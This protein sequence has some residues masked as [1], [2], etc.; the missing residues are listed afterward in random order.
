M[1]RSIDYLIDL[2]ASG[3]SIERFLKNRGYTKQGIVEIKKGKDNALVNGKWV[4]M[5]YILSEGDCLTINIYEDGESLKI[6]PVNLPFKVV[7]EDEDII[8]VDK[9]ANMPIHPSMNNY[10][11]TLGNALAYYYKSKGEKLIFRCI[12]RLDRDT[13]GLTIIAKHYL[14]AGILYNSMLTREIHREYRAIVEGTMDDDEGTVDLPIGR[15]DGSTIERCVDF[16]N[17]ERAVTHYK[18]ISRKNNMTELSLNLE[19]GRTHQI[20]VHMKSI[21]HPLIG[22]WLYNKDNKLLERQ[23]LHSYRLSFVHPI[24]QKQLEFV[25]DI[26][27][28]MRGILN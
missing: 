5:K 6:I 9:P 24:T 22:D 26:P 11:N 12:N 3:Y 1:K 14:S 19:T 27:D 17:G 2:E 20:R 18:V 23:A 28:D 7:Y 10:D 16:D 8:V 13:S 21:G 15:L 4:N 25:S